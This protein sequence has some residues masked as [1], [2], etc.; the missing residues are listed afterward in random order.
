MTPEGRG[1]LWC[2]TAALVHVLLDAHG[3]LLPAG[4]ERQQHQQQQQQQQQQ[5]QQ[6]IVVLRPPTGHTP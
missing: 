2:R 4:Q 1:S 6:N 3:H 5:L